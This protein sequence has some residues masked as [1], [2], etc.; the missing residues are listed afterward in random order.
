MALEASVAGVARLM[1]VLSAYFDVQEADRE[2]LSAIAD[3]AIAE[4]DRRDAP[5]ADLEAEDDHG[6]D[7]VG[8]A[9]G[10]TW[11]EAA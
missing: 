5:A 3:E 4:L 1:S 10:T 11:T 6:P 9:E 8:E 7:D 2:V